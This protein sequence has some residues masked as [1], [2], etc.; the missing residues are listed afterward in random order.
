MFR[1][2]KIVD[3]RIFDQF[4]LAGPWPLWQPPKAAILTSVTSIEYQILAIDLSIHMRLCL[5]L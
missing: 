1:S 3:F 5:L 2:S 4:F